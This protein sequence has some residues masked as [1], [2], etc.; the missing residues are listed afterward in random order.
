MS[1]TLSLTKVDPD[2]VPPE[3][4]PEQI[5]AY[6]LDLEGLLGRIDSANTYYQI[7]GVD[8]D[9]DQEK[10]RSAFHQLLN[11]LFP[12]YAIGKIMPPDMN[13]RI[14]NAFHKASL[15]FAALASFAAR[16]EYDLTLPSTFNKQPFIAAPI[17]SS[18]D[19]TASDASV[20]PERPDSPARAAN[21][22]RPSLGQATHRDW[23]HSARSGDNRRR[24]E[25]F[26]LS[27][28][29]RVTGQDR[30]AGKW[31]EMAETIDVS[32]TGVRIR[33]RKRVKH[34]TVLYL[35]LPLPTKLRAH[36]FADQSY[37]VYTLVR[38]VEPPRQGMRAV[39][40]E[41][42]GEHPPGGYLDKPWALFRPRKW[43]GSDRRR[44]DRREQGEYVSIEYFDEAMRSIS[45]E[46]ARTENVSQYGVR[47]FG[48]TAPAEFDLVMVVCPR[49]KFEGMAT[50]RSRYMGKD[51]LERICVQ[52]I[53]KEWPRQR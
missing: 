11:L 9:E 50:L 4:A 16:R 33:L 38:R 51:G 48:T 15:A 49:L 40:L 25:R 7:L 24:C 52:L 46:E 18:S 14:G 19:Q 43:G 28:P 44:P 2:P 29:V 5:S 41:F 1:T 23:G 30:Q 6:F 39:G 36:G 21:R 22:D 27:I 53:D 17:E 35:T 8:R 32:R 37:N 31:R 13:P 47:I 42:I 34:G 26:K 10:I 20:N 45:R 3:P 12:P